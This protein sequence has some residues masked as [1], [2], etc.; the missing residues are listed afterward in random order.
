[1][2]CLA[3]LGGQGGTEEDR[4]G[5]DMHGFLLA[6][7]VQTNGAQGR[8][9]FGFQDTELASWAREIATGY[10]LSMPPGSGQPSPSLGADSA[11]RSRGTLP[12][13]ALAPLRGLRR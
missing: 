3:G 8:H 5:E 12:R 6:R 13:A 10:A 1:M 7:V 11:L 2:L 9:V 4:A